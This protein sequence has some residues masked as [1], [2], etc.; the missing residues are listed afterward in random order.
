[1]FQ[2]S[3]PGLI[4]KT[5]GLGRF[6]IARRSREAHSHLNRGGAPDRLLIP[7]PAFFY[8]PGTMRSLELPYLGLFL[9][10]LQ[11]IHFCPQSALSDAVSSPGIR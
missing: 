5:F 2:E 1:M 3:C 9:Y 10:L 11:D 6:L 8:S 7:A 4:Q